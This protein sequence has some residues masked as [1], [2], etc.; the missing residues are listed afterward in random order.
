MQIPKQKQRITVDATNLAS[1]DRTDVIRVLH[2][3]DDL[4]MLGI[5]KAILMELGNFEIEHACCVDEAFEKL[6]AGGFDVVVSDYEMPQKDGLEFL[7]L[8]RER[9]FDVPFILF[10]G[11]GR[12]EVAIRAL[13]LGA[14]GYFNKQGDPGT[15]YGELGHGIKLVVENSKAKCA[16]QE[17]EFK[18]KTYV[19]SSPI[20]I[21]V[22]N[23]QANYVYVN[24]AACRLLGYSEEELLRM[25]IPEV[26]YNFEANL[27]LKTFEEA[28]KT[29][30]SYIEVALRSKE[31][32][33]VYVA[34]N[35]IKL[36]DGKLLAYCE[37]VS[38]RRKAE[39]E[40]QEKYEVLERVAESI[41]AGLAVITKDYQVSW[42]NSTLRSLGVSSNKKC[43]QTFAKWENV[44]PDC[45]VKK[46]FEQNLPFDVHEYKSVNSKGEVAWI[47]LRVTPL[48]DKDGNV[49]EALELAV[50]ITERKRMED[51]LRKSNE[52]YVNLFESARDVIATLDLKGNITSVN[53]AA[54][55]YG[56]KIEDIIG[57]NM[58][59]LVSEKYLPQIAQSFMSV[60][61]GSTS[62][63][64]FELG[65]PVGK[66]FVEFQA[67]PIIQ[68]GKIDGVLAILR[69]NTERKVAEDQL[70]SLKRFDERII[71][72][73]GD[74]LLIIDPEDYT[75]LNANKSV[76]DQLKLKRKDLIGKTCYGATHSRLVP[77]GS[78]HPCPIR[79]VMKSGKPITV[80][81]KHFDSDH[82]ELFVEVSAYPVKNVEGKT[83]VIHVSKD[84]TQR[85]LME[86]DLQASE[87]QFRAITDCA[88]DAIVMIDDEQ[89][90]VYWNPAA[91]RI[92]GYEKE[93]VL[94]KFSSF[95]APKHLREGM[96][97]GLSG[98]NKNGSISFA[99][100]LE[101][102]GR[103]KSGAEFPMELSGSQIQIGGASFS[104]AIIRDVTERKRM[105]NKLRE[106]SS[107]LKYMVE[108]RTAQ[109][110]DANERLVKSERLATIGELAGM[111]GHDLRNPLAGIKNATYFLKKKGTAIS[112]DS[113]QD[114]LGVIERAI[115]HS[116]KI[117][118]ELLDYA[119]EIHLELQDCSLRELLSDV[120]TRLNIPK[121]VKII[122]NISEKL[123]VR[124]D[125][126]KLGRVFMNL[127]KNAAD[128]MPNGGSL[129]VESKLVGDN[130]ELSFADTGVG[131]SEEILP[132][133]FLPLI[134]TKAQGMGF[135]LAI[136][137]RIVEA[138]RGT[139]R[140]ETV[141]GKGTTFVITLPR[142]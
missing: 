56:F 26:V 138:H 131:I 135:G 119:R 113:Y 82:N 134:T 109:L 126:D 99:G 73:L 44:C 11:K 21:F 71:D 22:A 112:E 66:V 2:V 90:V 3:D 116:D 101:T 67:S 69:N 65:T 140:V 34:I 16:L 25:S 129:T 91:E 79:Q 30:H 105:Q 57:E 78:E 106:Y 130:F 46:V 96:E 120:L 92:F 95:L 15:V 125:V 75:I 121:K 88:L 60:S 86:R 14:E 85:K 6:H 93:E 38:E 8:L 72:S 19:E 43:Y 1:L 49:I 50:P 52:R 117:V 104:V 80:E 110:K 98:L 89:R 84:I 103:K 39:L 94:G 87:E 107:H 108:L 139:I 48:K 114:M 35:A 62:K 47:E 136:C 12:E 5:S 76:L 83:V 111:V 61:Q 29:G 7:R 127:V 133:L 36:P 81:H 53:K 123:V 40:K 63:G 51:S 18:F 141:K 142:D 128:A 31:G 10:T 42:A 97:K 32:Q 132:K 4:S 28:K 59:Q 27:P 13:N 9:K 37:N 54:A 20:A 17:S 45:G 74:A 102:V 137:K 55:E 24:A 118:N 100:T 33:P 41:D 77:C 124:V 70:R 64:E 23:A 58:L 68:E 115:D 122:S